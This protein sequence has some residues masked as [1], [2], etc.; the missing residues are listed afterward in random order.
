MTRAGSAAKTTDTTSYES[1]VDW[2]KLPDAELKHF[3]G[4]QLRIGGCWRCY[5]AM[6]VAG[7][8]SNARRYQPSNPDP[9]AAV[10]A[11]MTYGTVPV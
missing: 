3:A 5:Y 2:Q 11:V 10:H 8:V 4:H 9:V 7:G 6:V 1:E